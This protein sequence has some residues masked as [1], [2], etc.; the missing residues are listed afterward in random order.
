MER[1]S[2]NATCRLSGI[3]FPSRSGIRSSV[4]NR[5]YG[6]FLIASKRFRSTSRRKKKTRRG[7]PEKMNENRGEDMERERRE[8]GREGGR[9]GRGER[10][11]HRASCQIVVD[12]FPFKPLTP[13]KPFEA[14]SFTGSQVPREKS[15]P[16]GLSR[17]IITGKRSLRYR[18]CVRRQ[19][20]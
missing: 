8:I 12:L 14:D 13:R 7:D 6:I 1:K 9:E 19:T 17:Q 18:S 16:E 10:S 20:R 5:F 11:N 15:M 2:R 4:R 3:N